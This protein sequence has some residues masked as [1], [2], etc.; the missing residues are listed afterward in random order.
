MVINTS[1]EVSRTGLQSVENE[2]G[3]TTAIGN[4]WAR[5]SR[6]MTG[7]CLYEWTAL[8]TLPDIEVGQRR[9]Y[10]PMSKMDRGFRRCTGFTIRQCLG[11]HFTA[12]AADEFKA[13]AQ[14]SQAAYL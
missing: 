8:M 11:C 5:G 6:L 3:K 12:V 13:C 14:Y 10:C 9:D 7:G 4:R 2:H 1:F